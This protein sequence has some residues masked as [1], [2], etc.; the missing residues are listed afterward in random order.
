M[1]G[2]R[3]R[4]LVAACALFIGLAQAL[5]APADPSLAGLAAADREILLKIRHDL[6]R[7]SVD[8][9][10]MADIRTRIDGLNTRYPG[11]YAVRLIDFERQWFEYSSALGFR[12]GAMS[13]IP[14]F[15]DLHREAPQDARPLHQAAI[16]YIHTQ[17]Y[18]GAVPWLD[19]AAAL[20]PDDPWV[21]LARALWHGNQL[22]R[23]Q[24][25]AEAHKA[26]KKSKGDALALSLA[27]RR[28]A[29]NWGISDHAAAAE[30]ADTMMAVEPYIA[31][32]TD[33]LAL[34]VESYTY[35][36]AHLA[37][38]V[39][40]GERLE[41]TPDHDAELRLQLVRLASFERN[42]AADPGNAR[43]L[44]DR[45]AELVATEPVSERARTLQ[46]NIAIGDGDIERAKALVEQGK[47][48]GMRR[49]WVGWALGAV[50]RAQ[51]MHK[52]VVA[53][54]EEYD[55]PDNISS[56]ESRAMTGGREEAKLFHAMMVENEPTN[57]IRLGDYAGFLFHFFGD[58]EQTIYHGARSYELWPD[59]LVANR[60]ASAYL[61][62]SAHLLEFG[63]E[64]DARAA[65]RQALGYNFNRDYMRQIC[66]PLCEEIGRALDEFR[67]TP[68]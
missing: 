44:A 40:L 42:V 53:T 23:P 59:P 64:S 3:I 33:A 7:W 50:Y 35:N 28:I 9:E 10:H 68:L 39:A 13:Y 18:A 60:V 1:V 49:A 55:L 17:D 56:M 24:A 38:A 26:L 62:R 20:A 67:E 45:L 41:K 22:Q 14:V 66:Y 58:Y 54:Y 19:K 37:V 29:H 27:V 12:K 25:V 36:P 51:R 57:P 63:N 46:L 52:E 15:L 2:V 65:Y 6:S 4:S 8:R 31:I 48:A 32:L 34:L 5:A 11:S 47:A 61:A 21:D 30:I 16:G 43:D